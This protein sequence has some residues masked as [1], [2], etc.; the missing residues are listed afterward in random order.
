MREF[1]LERGFVVVYEMCVICGLVDLYPRQ[2][3]DR[4]DLDGV[5]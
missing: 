1:G 3:C 5:V 4:Q 2:S